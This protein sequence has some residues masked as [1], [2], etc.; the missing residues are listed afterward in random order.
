MFWE[1]LREEE[2]QEYVTA[3]ATGEENVLGGFEGGVEKEFQL[4]VTT[5]AAG[6]RQDLG[7]F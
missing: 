5:A 3:A 6:E 7:G 2:F 4:H 1:I